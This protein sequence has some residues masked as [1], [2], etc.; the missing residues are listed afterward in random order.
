MCPYYKPHL[1]SLVSIYFDTP[2]LPQE[3]SSDFHFAQF[4]VDAP[5][6]GTCLAT[7][8]NCC[9]LM[10]VLS[11]FVWTKIIE[12]LWGNNWGPPDN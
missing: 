12:Q 6:K 2:P 1:L 4:F 5:E 8:C 7:V 11:N 10:L 3:N 9:D